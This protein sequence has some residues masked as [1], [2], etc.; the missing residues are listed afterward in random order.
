MKGVW[1]KTWS[2]RE[3]ESGGQLAESQAGDAHEQSEAQTV[4]SDDLSRVELELGRQR[5]GPGGAPVGRRRRHQS[6]G[7]PGRREGSSW[8]A[9]GGV[10]GE[11]ARRGAVAGP[12]RRSVRRA[13]QTV[14]KEI[15]RRGWSL[16]ARAPEGGEVVVGG[17]TVVVRDSG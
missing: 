16:G 14:E 1:Q 5:V 3:Q 11:G 12:E 15:E 2:A 7:W 9:C 8:G 4:G 13:G 6:K 10:G 17:A